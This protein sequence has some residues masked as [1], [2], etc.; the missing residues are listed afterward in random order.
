MLKTA[1]ITFHAP[2]NYGSALQA[3][4]LQ[5]VIKNMGYQNEIINYR[6][7][8]QKDCYRLIRKNVGRADIIKDF[9]QF[10]VF[11]KKR[12]RGKKFEQFTLRYL[13]LTEEYD[14]PEQL[15]EISEKYD[16]FISGSDQIWNKH[17][18]ELHAVDWKYMYPYLLSFTNR[19]KISYASSIGGMTDQELENIKEFIQK[20]NYISA[21]E[22]SVSKRIEKII[23]RQCDWVLDPTLLLSSN[24][25]IDKFNLKKESSNKYI[26]YYSLSGIN[27]VRKHMK[28]LRKLAKKEKCKIVVNTPYAFIPSFN[29]NIINYVD[30][31]P[32]NF[33]NNIYNSYAVITDSFHGTAFSV[34]F[35]KPF[36]SLCKNRA[37]SEY[38]KIELLEAI[39]LEKLIVEEYENIEDIK[40]INFSDSNKLILNFRKNSIKYLERALKETNI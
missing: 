21:R 3:F 31:D 13:H 15:N 26:F 23:Q 8:G 4:A 16:L 2:Y 37:G 20:F 10:P 18:N 28:W 25:Y 6:F 32:V 22:K 7:Q 1:L 38:R 29:R 30:M 11:S 5:Q 39:G 17:A 33:L 14:K 9:L 35:N 36:Y 12:Q 24:E 19:K 40:K 34:N 27:T